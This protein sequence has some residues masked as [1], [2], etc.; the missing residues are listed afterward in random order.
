MSINMVTPVTAKTIN[1]LN[2]D[3]GMLLHDFD[4]ST[5]KNAQELMQKITSEEGQKLWFGATKG[6]INVQEGRSSWSPSFD[7]KRMSY[8]GEERFSGAVP[9]MTGTLVEFTPANVRAISGAAEVDDKDKA[10]IKVQPKATIQSGHYFSNIVFVANNGPDGLYVAEMKNAMSVSGMNSQS[11][12]Q[13]IATLP[14]EFVAHSD[15]PVFTD[16]LPLTYWFFGASEEAA[17]A[18]AE[19]V[20]QEQTDGGAEG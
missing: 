19:Q 15:S 18:V 14:F 6:G 7:S 3:A 10:K 13:D 8:K 20:E 17:A 1:H 16:D 2:P 5:V 12:D 9:K 4:I 11:A